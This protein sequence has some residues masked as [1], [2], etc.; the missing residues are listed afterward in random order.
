M[1][2]S[3]QQDAA[4]REHLDEL[5]AGGGAHAKFDDV[6]KD[7]PQ[8]LRGQK[9]A[10]MPHSHMNQKVDRRAAG[11]TLEERKII[12]SRDVYGS[13]ELGDI[14]TFRKM[15]FYVGDALRDLCRF[16]YA[17]VPDALL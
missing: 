6:V 9:P 8:K 15:P 17:F 7:I 11:M 3:Q 13:S 1:S 14:K 16:P 4:L 12:R 10:G 5:L 2:D